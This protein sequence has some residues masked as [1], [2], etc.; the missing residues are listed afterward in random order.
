MRRPTSQYV[1]VINALTARAE[2]RRAV[3]SSSA[4]PPTKLE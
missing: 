2:V 4:M 3:S 1:A